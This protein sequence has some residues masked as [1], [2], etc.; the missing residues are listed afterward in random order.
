M[1]RKSISTMVVIE[2]QTDHKGFQDKE[3]ER[4][5]EGDQEE[6]RGDITPLLFMM[7]S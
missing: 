7:I 2:I 3:K 4:E 6:R 1:L 5:G